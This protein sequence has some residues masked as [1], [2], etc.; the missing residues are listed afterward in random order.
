MLERI[1]SLAPNIE[2]IVGVNGNYGE[3]FDQDFRRQVLEVCAKYDNVFP[4][5]FPTF[6]GW[7]KINNTMF[8]QASNDNILF[9]SLLNE[10]V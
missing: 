5:S 2:V 6:R 9:L 1:K 10:R 4:I 7:A 8:L 3:S